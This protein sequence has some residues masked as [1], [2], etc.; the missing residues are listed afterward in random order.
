MLDN[1]ASI[2]KSIP[3]IYSLYY[4]MPKVSKMQLLLMTSQKVAKNIEDNRNSDITYPVM[5]SPVKRCPK[6]IS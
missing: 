5:H 3:N 6:G 2:T 1:I 4:E